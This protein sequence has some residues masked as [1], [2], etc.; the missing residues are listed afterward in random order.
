MTIAP[1]PS[2]QRLD[3][4]TFRPPDR[5]H[6][7]SSAA[8]CLHAV[9]A[10][11]E[12]ELLKYNA[13]DPWYIG[14]THTLAGSVSRVGQYAK[15]AG[16][17]FVSRGAM[18]RAGASWLSCAAQLAR[19]SNAADAGLGLC[20]LAHGVALTRHPGMHI[21]DDWHPTMWD[22]HPAAPVLTIQGHDKLSSLQQQVLAINP[23]GFAQRARFMW[24]VN[25]TS[26]LVFNIASGVSVHAWR[27][28]SEGVSVMSLSLPSNWTHAST[29]PPPVKRAA[30]SGDYRL[31]AVAW[32]AA[33]SS[34]Q[35]AVTTT[36]NAVTA[37][38]DLVPFNRVIVHEPAWVDRWRQSPMLLCVTRW[39]LT[40]GSQARRST[41][42]LHLD[43]GPSG[44]IREGFEGKAR[45]AA[46]PRRPHHNRRLMQLES[47]LDRACHSTHGSLQNT[48][49]DL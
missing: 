38:H 35:C 9:P 21:T 30:P 32:T 16:G 48:I 39:H 3:T 49:V 18:A 15:A 13:S 34:P 43:K 42:I 10:N 25:Q 1:R 37:D 19:R 8:A 6:P 4:T 46:S 36:Y 28:T 26:S 2:S 23:G 31:A 45:P 47:K 20:L 44:C 24:R 12:V 7:F 33:G 41:L 11:I 40:K 22:H 27:N 29:N 14:G 17:V 5:H